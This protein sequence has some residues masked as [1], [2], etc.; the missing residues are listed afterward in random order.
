MEKKEIKNW[1]R[2]YIFIPLKGKVFCLGFVKKG[3]R[4]RLERL[5]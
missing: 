3:Y 4:G 5:K 2:V 1:Q